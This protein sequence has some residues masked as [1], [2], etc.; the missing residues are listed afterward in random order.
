MGRTWKNIKSTKVL[1]IRNYLLEQGG[2]EKE[3]KSEHEIWRI[4]LLDSTFT[5]YKKGT[6]YST[7]SN[8]NSPAVVKAWEYIDSLVGSTYVLTT[9]KDFLIGL[10]ETGKGEVIGD[11][12]LTGVVFPKKLFKD[13]ELLVGV[14]DTKKKHKFEYWDEIFKKL[15]YLR[16]SGFNFLIE[17]IPPWHVDKYNLNKIMDVSYQ[18]ILSIFFRR[19]DISR[20]RIV[21]DDYGIG[22]ALKRFLN[23]LKNQGAEIIVTTHSEDKYLEAK[24][25]ALISKRIREAVIKTINENPKFQIDGL[26]VGSGN[27]ADSQTLKWLKKWHASGKEWPWFIKR[28]FK[29]I[30]NIEGKVGKPQ[31]T[32]PPIR[33]ELLS[34]E[35]LEEFNKGRLSIQSFSI[36]CPY[37]ASISKSATFV[38]FKSGGQ[39][40][41]ELK[42][43]NCKRLIKNAGIT[44]R[45]YCGYIVPDG[46]VLER[47]LISRDLKAS[48]FFEN[49]T[50]ILTPVVRK[51]CDITP[52][53]KKELDELEKYNAIGR[54]KLEVIGKVS[55]LPENLSRTVRDE[56]IIK[57]CIE[58]NA[59]LL[60][61][62]KSMYAFAHS[63]NIFT[64]II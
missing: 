41:S 12:V 16:S 35:F 14:A 10:D 9:K 43:V 59:I 23:F 24:T 21:L 53:S 18:R 57:A 50:I 64:I 51:E 45:Y 46:S 15:D 20:C 2:I 4:K 37:C 38:I 6:L 5:L 19:I 32:L 29:T 33:E 28:S 49:F 56:E 55:D 54:I 30:W 27:L 17:R 34:D 11:T 39:Q 47:N 48:K 40:I 25:A 3:I 44:L 22:A 7:S 31:K 13:V 8:S 63:K 60:T 62:D 61:S 1:E 58:Y 52:R 36:V 42:C 26:S